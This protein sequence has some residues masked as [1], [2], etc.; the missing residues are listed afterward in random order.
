MRK[1]L[2]LFVFILLSGHLYS[3][4]V[5]DVVMY[6]LGENTPQET[7]Y[8]NKKVYPDSVPCKAMLLTD[9]NNNK[10]LYSKKAKYPYPNAST[11]KLMTA[12]IACEYLKP[13]D[14][15]TVSE[16]ASKTPFNSMKFN[17]GEY[18]S[19][20]DCLGA[21]LVRSANDTAVVIAENVA[22]SEEN[23]VSLMNKKAYE[24]GCLNTYFVTASGLHH[25][26]HHT[27]CHDLAIIAKEA[28]KEPLIKKYLNTKS[29]QITTRE[30]PEGIR[31][32]KSSNNYILNYPYSAG[33]KS[34]FTTP[35]GN[36]MVCFGEKEDKK[37][38]LVILGVPVNIQKYLP[39]IMNWG[40]EQD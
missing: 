10:V 20:E 24:L 1:F 31:S 40:F 6:P 38:L 14:Y 3:D 18:I 19:F 8:E 32:I 12:L 16:K 9:L 22:G 35:A 39:L 25:K 4:T 23:F 27:T 36:C 33:A 30:N 29:F 11:T 15:L 28:I 26:S 5:I 37:L 21:M 7:S 2:I 13:T 17:V 34:G